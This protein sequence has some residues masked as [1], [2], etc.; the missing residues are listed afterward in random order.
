[1]EFNE[2]LNALQCREFSV[3]DSFWLN[4]IEFEV[5]NMKPQEHRLTVKR[6]QVHCPFSD[7]PNNE[8]LRC[9]KEEMTIGED[10]QCMD[11]PGECT[12]IG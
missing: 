3:G 11:M 5:K 10:G 1:M 9:K 7:C 6:T 8:E 2:F 4:S 12:T